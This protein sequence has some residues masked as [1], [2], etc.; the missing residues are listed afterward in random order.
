VRHGLDVLLGAAKALGQVQLRQMRQQIQPIQETLRL[1]RLNTHHRTLRRV[2][3]VPPIAELRHPAPSLTVVK[4]RGP[5]VKDHDPVRPAQ[6]E[7]RRLDRHTPTPATHLQ[8]NQQV[9]RPVVR[10][11]IVVVINK[12]LVRQRLIDRQGRFFQRSRGIRARILAVNV[13]ASQPDKLVFVVH[14]V[15]V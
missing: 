8:I 7:F 10:Q 9:A 14:R 2:V 6:H 3:D 11:L 13:F 1:S 4:Q 5:A 15:Q 12:Q